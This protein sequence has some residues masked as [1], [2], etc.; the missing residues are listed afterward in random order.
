MYNERKHD[1]DEYAAALVMAKDGLIVKLTPEGKVEFANGIGRKGDP[2]YADGLVNGHTYEQQT[3]NPQS[4]SFENLKNAVDNALQ[5]ARDKNA[6][7]PLIYDKYGKFH[8]EHIEA[9]LSQFEKYYPDY[10]FKAILVVDI[11]GNL[12]EH[13]HNK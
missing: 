10:K 8:R 11:H 1:P 5:H 7:L 13:Q 4:N 6:S 2:V 9:G 12:W 3:K